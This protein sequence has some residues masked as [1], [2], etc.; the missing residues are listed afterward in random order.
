MKDEIF[1]CLEIGLKLLARNSIIYGM[2]DPDEEL[3]LKYIDICGRKGINPI[4]EVES[5]L[6]IAPRIEDSFKINK[7][8]ICVKFEINENEIDSNDAAEICRKIILNEWD[9]EMANI[10]SMFN[11]KRKWGEFI[12]KGKRTAVLEAVLQ[13]EIEIE[14]GDDYIEM[15]IK[16]EKDFP[17]LENR[18][19]FSKTLFAECESEYSGMIE[20]I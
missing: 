1:E 11:V 17:P 15:A 20:I 19:I 5:A 18:N 14:G 10:E 6:N 9:I 7:L 4:S 3:F 8:R 16:H 13:K 2:D 12:G